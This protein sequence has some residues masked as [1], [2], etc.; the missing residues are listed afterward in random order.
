MRWN[1]LLFPEE[2]IT[3]CQRKWQIVA[4]RFPEVCVQK[5]QFTDAQTF[6]SSSLTTK[7]WAPI[8]LH[9]SITV[10]VHNLSEWQSAA[11]MHNKYK[12]Y[13]N[14]SINSFRYTLF[15]TKD[16]QYCLL[17]IQSATTV[18]TAKLAAFR[19]CDTY[20]TPFIAF[21]LYNIFFCRAMWIFLCSM[22][23]ALT[24]NL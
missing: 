23:F 8:E 19:D 7:I 3:R 5:Y 14:T 1:R 22:I 18:E 2:Y 17:L 20:Y 9:F 15:F 24:Y 12:I 21:V 11:R 13:C 10:I 16:F 6:F 4:F